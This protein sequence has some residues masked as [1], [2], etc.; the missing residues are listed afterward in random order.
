MNKLTERQQA[1]LDFIREHQQQT[2]FPPTSR[3]IQKHFGFQSQTAA[4]NHLR[5]LER[6][7]VIQR[8]PGK[9][10]ALAENEA[11]R[12]S[13]RALPLLGAIPAGLPD[14]GE[15]AAD[16][17]TFAVDGRFFGLAGGAKAFALKV[18]GESMIDAQIA[19]GDTVILEERPARNGDIV[20]ALIDGEV[21]LKRLVVQ[22]GR[23]YLK[24]ENS[25]YPDLEPAQELAIQ[26]VMVGLIRKTG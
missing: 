7:N 11:V 17:Q 24:A 21:T 8:L 18:R 26:G 1:V 6:K 12:P 20:A 16:A 15:S 19:D 10:R 9:A 22:R 13:F 4:M 23:S 3:E 2:G 14:V 25:A 5:A